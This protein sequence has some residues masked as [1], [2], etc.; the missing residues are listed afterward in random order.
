MTDLELT[1]A[2]AQK[3]EPAYSAMSLLFE[4]H[5]RILCRRYR[6]QFPVLSEDEVVDIVSNSMLVAFEKAH[7]FKGN[8]TFQTWLGSIIRNAIL[9]HLDATKRQNHLSIDASETDEQ[10]FENK[11]IIDEKTPLTEYQLK[12]LGECVSVH[13]ARF[14]ERNPEASMA[15]FEHFIENTDF[16]ELSV[17]LNRSYGATR[18]F[19]SKEAAKLR[20]FLEPCLVHLQL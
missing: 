14:R 10:A 6:Y 1:R 4:R 3:G 18:Q 15:I 19:V 8:S 17:L 16:K 2:I 12:L 7:T 5:F 11:Y 13:F 9:N 20:A